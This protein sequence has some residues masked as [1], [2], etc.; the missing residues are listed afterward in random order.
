LQYREGTF[1][2]IFVVKVEDGDELIES[3]KKVAEEEAVKTAAFI[4]LGALREATFVSGPKEPVLPPEQVWK[5]FSDGREIMGVGTIYK[6]DNEPSIHLHIS[7]GKGEEAHVGCLRETGQV[8]IV[9]EVV[10]FEIN[11]IE[12]ERIFDKNLGLKT[13]KFIN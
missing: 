4:M 13:I 10:I 9:V 1:G 12:A 6:S 7:I 8:Y 3:I 2:R 5:S 11:G